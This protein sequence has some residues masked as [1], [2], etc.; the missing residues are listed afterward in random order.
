MAEDGC[1]RPSFYHDP[2]PRHD[3]RIM[4]YGYDPL[5]LRMLRNLDNFVNVDLLALEC[6]VGT[7]KLF[8]ATGESGKNDILTTI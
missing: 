8:G 7:V 3:V 4:G 1:E 2:L 5:F 6:L